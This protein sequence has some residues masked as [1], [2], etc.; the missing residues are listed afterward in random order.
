MTARIHEEIAQLF[1]AKLEQGVVPWRC[2]WQG[3]K[4][5]GLPHNAQSKRKYSGV[6]V[7]LTWLAAAEHG[8][9]SNGWLTYKQAQALGGNVRKGEKSTKIIFFQMLETKDKATG[10]A[11][12]VPMLK[13]YSIF[14]VEQC[15]G[16]PRDDAA[17]VVLNPDQRD[18][19]AD[20][21]LRDTGA[22]L[23]H[24]GERAFYSPADDSITLPPFDRFIGRD[25]YYNTAFHELTH[26]TG[27]E[28]RLNRIKGKRFGD[29][30][31][32]FE[33]LV[34]ELGAAFMCA[35]FGFTDCRNNSASYIANWLSA[36]KS[37]PSMIMTAASDASKAHSYIADLVA[38]DA[39]GLAA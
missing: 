20:Q 27:S 28:K 36:F 17:P 37:H 13:W 7:V 12:A 33:E 5:V 9:A 26:W 4:P 21:M 1:I 22:T 29:R 38:A 31:Y 2:P 18:T 15:D 3:G 25:E 11:K 34:A 30:E 14:N 24:G 19:L 39:T 8:F 32:S 23:K 35:D 16:L 10:K 6:N